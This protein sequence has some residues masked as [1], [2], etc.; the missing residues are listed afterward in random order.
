[1]S[2][3]CELCGKEFKNTQGLRGHKTFVHQM[4]SS[5]SKSPTPLA[6]EQQLSKL[7]ERL[8]RVERVTGLKE[9]SSLDQILGTDKPITE[10]LEQNTRQLA[11]LSNQ[12]KDL[13]QQVRLATSSTEVLNIKRQLTQLTEQV[14]RHDKWMTTSPVMLFLSRNSPDCPAFLLELNRLK[15]RVDDHQG[16]INLT[17]KKLDSR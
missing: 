4:H 6:T 17:R 16:A 11:E 15:G 10:R 5:S 2:V 1:M 8:Q 7:D 9:P 3:R 14:S 12:L 13:S